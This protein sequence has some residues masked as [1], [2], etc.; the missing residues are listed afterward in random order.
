MLNFSKKNIVLKDETC[1]IDSIS[2]ENKYYIS[3]KNQGNNI[4]KAELKFSEQE[5][6]YK[7]L[8]SFMHRA[9]YSDNKIYLKEKEEYILLE[10]YINKLE[11][12]NKNENLVTM[13]LK[14]EK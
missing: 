6:N 3:F 8:L 2:L 4:Y 10:S 12:F 9:I 14:K 7:K 5:N 1:Y 11:E 13:I